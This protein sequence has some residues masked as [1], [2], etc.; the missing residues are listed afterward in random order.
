MNALTVNISVDWRAVHE[1]VIAE[2]ENIARE[3]D[4]NGEPITAQMFR[5][6][7]EHRR[8]MLE[9]LEQQNNEQ[10]QETE[11]KGNGARE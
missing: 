1:A 5:E 11:N 9:K 2:Y 3:C 6:A 8:K 10:G 4:A 7:A